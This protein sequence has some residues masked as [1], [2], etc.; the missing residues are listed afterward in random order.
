MK[1]KSFTQ[2]NR[3]L[4]L[5]I[6]CLRFKY[7]RLWKVMVINMSKSENRLHFI[8]FFRGVA[9]IN[10]IFYHALFDYFV[11]YGHDTSWISYPEIQIWERYICISFIFIS[12]YSWH[13]GKQKLKRGLLLSGIG[14]I[15]TIVTQLVMPSQVIIFGI[16]SFLGAAALLMI[17]LEKAFVKV[18]PKILFICSIILFILFYNFSSFYIGI[19][20]Y[21]LIKIPEILTEMKLLTI[22]GLPYSGFYSSDYFPILPWLFVFISGYSFERIISKKNYYK[23]IFSTKVPFLSFIGTYSLPIYIIHQPVLMLL[24]ILLL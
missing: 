1:N 18:E 13:F 4:V 7:C 23:T 9:I 10:M 2:V 20:N 5:Q 14:I 3:R 21:Q 6:L 15:I 16:I 12:G 8:D 17:P 22:V 24:C 19:G 11:V